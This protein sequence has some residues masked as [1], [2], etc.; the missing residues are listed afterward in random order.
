MI[1]K[2]KNS[3]ENFIESHLADEL[4]AAVIIINAAALF[5]M[6]SPYLYEKYGFWLEKIDQYALIFFMCEVTIRM[7]V[8]KAD[9]FRCSWNIFDLLIIIISIL[10]QTGFLTVLRAF[11]ILR[12]VRLVRFLPNMQ[13]LL[14]SLRSAAPGVLSI[15]FFMSL[16]FL[17]FSLIAFNLYSEVESKC[18]ITITETLHTMLQLIL[19]INWINIIKPIEIQFPHSNYFF[20]FYI[21]VMKFTLLNLFFGLII[22]S[23]QSASE[24]ESKNTVDILKTNIEAATIIETEMERNLEHRVDTLTEEI[25]SLKAMITKLL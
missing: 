21:V 3:I 16:S 18:F 10:P 22:N 1:S 11:R 8:K 5:M 2:K 20:V 13:F 15:I 4:F 25:K 9:F 6:T 14:M 24:K 17:I 7:W 12:V 19:D 23:M